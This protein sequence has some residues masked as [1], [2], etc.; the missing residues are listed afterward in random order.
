MNEQHR[1]TAQLWIDDK[2]FEV[3]L[4]VTAMYCPGWP[5]SRDEEEEPEG[6]EVLNIKLGEYTEGLAEA[7]EQKLMDDMDGQALQT[8]VEA[9]EARRDEFRERFSLPAFPGLEKVS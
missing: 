3:E 5:A 7:I 1:I 8:A 9:A 6:Y 4:D 2:E